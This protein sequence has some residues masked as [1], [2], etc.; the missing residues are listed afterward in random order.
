MKKLAPIAAAI[1]A[2]GA[3]HAQSSVTI[4]GLLDVNV[5]RYSGGGPSQTVLGTDGLQSSRIG[6]RGQEDL[7][8]GLSASFWLE[9]G[10]NPDSGTGGTSNT[11]NQSTGGAGGGGIVFG[12]RSTVSLSGPFGEVRL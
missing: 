8:G 3:A 6:F 2:C 1:L 5:G 11:N 9:S 10:I 12:R 4:F 7:G